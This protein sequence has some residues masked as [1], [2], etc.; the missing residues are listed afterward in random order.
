MVIV[1]ASLI[2]GN[3]RSDRIIFQSKDSDDFVLIE[4]TRNEKL[5]M[6]Y[7]HNY[8]LFIAHNE[9]YTKKLIEFSSLSSVIQVKEYLSVLSDI[10]DFE[11]A[12]RII[13]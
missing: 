6:Y 11:L 2:H 7:D 4:A 10:Q 8:T 13:S 5:W 9:E 3:M 12:S 1:Y